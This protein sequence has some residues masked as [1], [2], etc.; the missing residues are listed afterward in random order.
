MLLQIMIRLEIL[1]VALLK[2]FL[3]SVALLKPQKLQSTM[4]LM[5]YQMMLV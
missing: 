2:M 4:Y 1:L 5:I 3:Q